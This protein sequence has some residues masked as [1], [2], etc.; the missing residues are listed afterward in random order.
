MLESEFEDTI[1]AQ[2]NRIF[3]E[4]SKQAFQY[5]KLNWPLHQL[6]RTYHGSQQA[7]LFLNFILIKKNSSYMFDVILTVHHH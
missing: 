6:V 1:C 3:N 5:G 2:G 7:A 4:L